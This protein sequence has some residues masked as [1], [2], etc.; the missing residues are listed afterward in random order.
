MLARHGWRKVEPDTCHPKRDI[1][2][3][4]ELKKNCPEILGEARAQNVQNRPVRLMFEDEARFGRISD[5][6]KCR[7]PAPLRPIV[8][9]ALVRQYADVMP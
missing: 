4:E 6:R 3:Q 1:E 7:A 8:R 2:A 5:P 9:Q